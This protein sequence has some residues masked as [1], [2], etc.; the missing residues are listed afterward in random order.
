LP[1]DVVMIGKKE[2]EKIPLLSSFIKKLNYLTVDRTDF[3]KNEEDTMKIKN[4][5]Q[6][7]S[8]IVLFPEGTFTYA[9]GIRPFKMGA[10][11]LSVDTQTLIC[12]IAFKG[13]SNILRSQSML[14][15]PGKIEVTILKPLQPESSDWNEAIRLRNLS[16]AEIAKYSGEQT[17][18]LLD[19]R[20]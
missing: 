15:R 18:D 17:L 3:S 6:E 12:P 2:I 4:A 11:V 5:I 13:T 7:G 10:F 9:A 14:P 16:R 1:S 8:S 20:L 19:I